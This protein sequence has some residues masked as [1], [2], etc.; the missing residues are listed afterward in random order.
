MSSNRVMKKSS[1]SF[2]VKK[3]I[4][5][6]SRAFEII[7]ERYQNFVFTIVF[8][9]LKDREEAEEVAQDTFIKAFNSLSGFREESKFSTWLY[10][11]AY[12]KALDRLRKEN[13]NEN[14]ILKEELKN[15]FETVK[16][17]LELMLQEERSLIVKNAIQQLEPLEATIV[18]FYYLEEYSIKEIAEVTG[19]SE[20]NIKVKLFRSR[21]VLFCLL[22]KYM[23]PKN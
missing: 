8:R 6:D 5:G 19:V 1:D 20:V 10:K 23:E 2:L 7:V 13:F 22:Q 12:R 4:N 17:G 14:Q 18:T 21:K 9:I 16:N 15:D 11:I 3:I